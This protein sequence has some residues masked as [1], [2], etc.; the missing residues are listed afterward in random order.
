VSQCDKLLSDAIAGEKK[1]TDTKESLRDLRARLGLIGL[2]GD[3]KQTRQVT[4]RLSKRAKRAQPHRKLRKGRRTAK[5]D[6]VAGR[7]LS[8]STIP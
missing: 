8:S 6:P 3:E 7:G 2:K 1:L 5:R 4:S